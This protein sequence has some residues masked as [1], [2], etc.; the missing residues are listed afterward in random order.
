MENIREIWKMKRDRFEG[1]SVEFGPLLAE[2]IRFNKCKTIV[3]IGVAWGTTTYYLCQAGEFVHGFDIWEVHGLEKQFGRFSSQNDVRNYLTSKG[4][5]NFKLHQV[6][7]YSPEFKNIIKNIGPIDFAFI[8]GCHSH[9]G[10]QNDFNTVLPLLSRDG[11]IAFHDVHSIDGCREFLIDLRIM[12]KYD[13]IDFPYGNGKRR[14]GIS[15]LKTR[16]Q[17]E[18]QIDEICGSP[19]TPEQIYEKEKL[20]YGYSLQR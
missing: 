6:D 2:L 19:S 7:T 15:I 18:K 8:D 20:Y 12:N 11:I 16:H 17:T 9:K 4:L 10:V 3:E 1:F 14:C 13:L 5:S